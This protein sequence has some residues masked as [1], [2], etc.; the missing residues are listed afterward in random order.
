[1]AI[2]GRATRRKRAEAFARE[3]S[4]AASRG[5]YRRAAAL[6]KAAV[7]ALEDDEEG[8]SQG[9]FAFESAPSDWSAEQQ[10]TS[11]I[12]EAGCPAGAK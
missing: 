11:E 2:D 3:A 7:V 5:E 9:E 8:S 6:Y 12:A 4:E 10:P 1:M